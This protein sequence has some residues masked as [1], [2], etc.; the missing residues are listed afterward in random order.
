MY[1]TRP[2][3]TDKKALLKSKWNIMNVLLIKFLRKDIS[4][5]IIYKDLWK[6]KNIQKD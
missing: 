1:K 2:T 4:G 3:W 5:R 6:K